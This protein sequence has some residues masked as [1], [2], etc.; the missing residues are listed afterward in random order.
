[1]SVT[2]DSGDGKSTTGSVSTP[3]SEQGVKDFT[4]PMWQKTAIAFVTEN[5]AENKE[6]SKEAVSISTKNEEV[7]DL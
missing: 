4:S 2:K 3:G 7:R 1:M 5:N 6:N